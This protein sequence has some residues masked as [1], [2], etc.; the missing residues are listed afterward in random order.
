LPTTAGLYESRADP[1]VRAKLLTFIQDMAGNDPNLIISLANDARPA[2]SMRL[3]ALLTS[4]P[5]GKGVPSLLSFVMFKNREIKLEVIH[6]LGDMRS[7]MANRI[8]MG[9]LNDPDEDLRIQA[10]MKLD[11]SEER[12][13]I[14][15]IIHEAGTPSFRKKSLKEKQA[16]MS[17]LGRTRTPDALAFLGTVL[18]R[19]AVWPSARTLEMRLAAVQ[20][21][22][23]M[24]GPE[25]M[26][27]L[28]AATQLRGKKVRQAAAEALA[29]LRQGGTR[30]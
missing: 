14:D 15:H 27:A 29:R 24:A 28:E 13:R 20:G 26:S 11:P 23:S 9:F 1:E 16:I 18:T 2:L 30:T 5:G 12:S 6:T 10:A 25:A 22:E 21:L 4:L 8:L 17:F 3:I 19:T 7:E